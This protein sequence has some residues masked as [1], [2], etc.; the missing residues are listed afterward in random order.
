MRKLLFFIPFILFAKNLMHPE[1]PKDRNH[2]SLGF[3]VSGDVHISEDVFYVGQTGSSLNNGSVYMYSLNELGGMDQEQLMAPIQGESGYDFGYSIDVEKNYMIIG[4][5]HR[6]NSNG[7]AYLYRKN[8]NSSWTLIKTIAPESETWT[9]DFGSEVAISHEAI[10]IGDRNAS[11]EQGMVY[12]LFKDSSQDWVKGN[13]IYYQSINEEGFFG[14]AISLDDQHALIGSRDGNVAVEYQFDS[15][16]KSWTENYV[17]KPGDYQSKGRFGYAVELAGNYAVIGSPGYDQK[18]Q[19]EIHKLNSGNWEKVKTIS[20]PDGREE[21]YFGSSVSLDENVLAVGNYNGEKAFIFSNPNDGFTL[22]QSI[23][24][25]ATIHD[26][27]FGRSINVDKNQIVIGATYGETA[28]IYTEDTNGDWISANEVSSDNQNFSIAGGRVPCVGG[29][30]GN[31]DCNSLDLMAFLSPEDLSGTKTELNDIWGWTDITT[32]KEYALVGLRNGTSFVDISDPINPFVVGFLPTATHSST[33]RDI[34]VYKNHAY[35]VADRANDHGVQVFDLEGLRGIS[36]FT[37]FEP[38][39][40]YTNIG[41]AHNIAIN[42]AT[43]FAYVTGIA[44][45]PTTAYECGKGLHMID[46]TNPKEPSFAGCFSHT[47][48]GRSGTGY[49]HDAQ[50]VVYSGPDAD[51]QGKEIA[52]SCNETALSIADISDKSNPIIISKFRGENF[53]Y[54]HQGWLSEDQNYFF[55]NDELNETRGDDDEQTTIIFDLTDLDNPAILTTYYSGL[56]TIDHNNYVRGDLL[57]QSNYSAGLRVL[58][59]KNVANPKEVAFFD[60]YQAGNILDY[61]GSW[62]NYPFLSSGTILV[63]SIEEGLFIL[64]GSEGGNLDT[65]GEGIIPENFDLIQNYPNPF[66][67]STRIRYELPVAGEITLTLYN[68][69]GMEVMQLDRGVKKAGIHYV[70]INARHLPNGIYLYQLRAGSFVKTR[71]MSLIK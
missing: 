8:E 18:G 69:L 56:N 24:S 32:G 48:T 55:V 50:I 33:W 61:V 67:P 6:A 25:P 12:T 14:H 20:N 58:H 27:K 43:G 3:G 2:N 49:T 21:Y 17:F 29:K 51:Y 26:G 9:M 30:A 53:G 28:Y 7:R 16:S 10:L 42:E 52:F 60:T 66:N 45:A 4:A 59:V 23:E 36:T 70:S 62:S 37:E 13:P 57:F 65:V 38:T 19:I 44:S 15:S 63:S 41:S 39:A 1:D 40:H 68:L 31:Y 54:I 71:K 47:G 46:I 22:K 34:K 5:P 64:K 11:H 35:I